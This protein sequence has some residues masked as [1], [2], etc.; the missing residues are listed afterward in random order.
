MGELFQGHKY[1]FKKDGSDLVMLD[2][3]DHSHETITFRDGIVAS[4]SLP[5]IIRPDSSAKGLKIMSHKNSDTVYQCLSYQ[6]S[7]AHN[8]EPYAYAL[9]YYANSPKITFNTDL[10][11]SNT[12]YVQS[13]EDDGA[14]NALL[15]NNNSAR[16]LLRVRKDGKIYTDGGDFYVR[17]PSNTAQHT[18]IHTTATNTY[19]DYPAGDFEIRQSSGNNRRFRLDGSV[20]DSLGHLR[21]V[22]NN[23]YDVGS[24]TL[25]WDDIRATNGTIQTSDRTLKEHISGS[26]LGLSFINDLNPVS[27]RWIG[28][29]RNHYGLIAQEVSESL[30]KSNV[31]VS[32]FA[33][34]IKDD[35]Y[36]RTKQIFVPDNNNSGSYENEE[37]Y[38]SVKE[39]TNNPDLD[40]SDYTYSSTTL[41]LRYTE[42]ISPLIKA[43]QELS[44]EVNYLKARVTELENN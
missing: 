27:Y 6:S 32:D 40:I 30:S 2:S 21:P 34:Y 43:V 11:A 1:T 12:I 13:G 37:D 25:R 41:A 16:D 29:N 7:A 22:S 8:S 35:V 19:I 33:G 44:A 4:G 26:N 15:I 20:I 18:R 31:N 28:K 14:R 38:Q 5:L 10:D 36:H 42:F 9:W 39:I 23:V 3:T 17:N 24:S